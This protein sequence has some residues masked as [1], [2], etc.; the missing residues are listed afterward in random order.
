MRKTEER[1]WHIGNENARKDEVR[2]HRIKGH[3]SNQLKII[4]MAALERTNLF[5]KE[6]TTELYYQ[7]ISLA[8][9][10]QVGVTKKNPIRSFNSHEQIT[11]NLYLTKGEWMRK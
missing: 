8:L 4:N 1:R 6:K 11:K 7:V 3:N 10:I 9:E 2:V 5:R